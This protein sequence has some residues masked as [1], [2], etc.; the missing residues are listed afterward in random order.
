MT[1]TVLETIIKKPKPK[2]IAYLNY[3][4]FCNL[5]FRE[6]LLMKLLSLFFEDIT[7]RKFLEIST[8]VLNSHAP[9]KQKYVR[10]NQA[11]F[12]NKEL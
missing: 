10:A 3:K 8:T 6:E 12:M 2:I 5:A 1:L 11:P 4:S 7:I 9:L